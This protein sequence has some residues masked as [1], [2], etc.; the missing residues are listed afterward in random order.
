MASGNPGAVQKRKKSNYGL[1]NQTGGSGSVQSCRIIVAGLFGLLMA[2][3]ASAAEP[4]ECDRIAGS[5]TDPNRVGAGISLY[6]IEPAEAIAACERALA[7]DP[8]NPR[9]L[10]NLG[11]AHAAR[12]LVDNQPDQKAQAG[13]N[14]K[15]AAD[16]DYPAAQVE[17]AAF[18]W[19]G[20]GGFQQD[21]G[22]AMRLLVKA[23]V[24]DA[25]EAKSQREDL[26]GDATFAPD[27][28]EAQIRIVKEAADAGDADAL[29][30]LSLPLNLGG[31]GDRQAELSRLL[32][33]AAA[34]GSAPAARDLAT[35]YFWGSHGLAKNPEESLRLFQQAVAGDDPRT[36]DSV[37]R[38]YE[39]GNLGLPKDEKQ[40]ARLFKQASDEGNAYAQYN[41]GRFYEEGK[42]GLPQD[43]HEAARLYKLA[44]DQGNDDATLALARYIA[45]G[46]GGYEADK[47]KA[48]EYLKR[49]ARW[50]TM[51]KDELTKMGG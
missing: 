6:G 46:R 38:L 17:L 36:W 47:T 8:H 51:A 7:A 1:E 34:L 11:R 23:M 25:K 33:K 3:A 43:T 22:E 37:A 26:F 48:V 21:T 15:A 9:L 13:Q 28:N 27:P 41:L 40:A 44:A 20:R 42:G 16:Q 31:G 29:Y 32:H 5:P 50:S 39:R 12:S 35:M 2:G 24:A 14:F 49:A 30:A 45:E 18:Y 10:F 4:T 19:F